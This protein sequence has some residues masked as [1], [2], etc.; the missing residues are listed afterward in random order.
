[1]GRLASFSLAI[2]VI[3]GFIGSSAAEEVCITCHQELGGELARAVKEWR[4]SVHQEAGVF[5]SFCHGGNPASYDHAMDKKTGFVSKPKPK[6]GVLLCARCHADVRMM[7]QY[8]LRTDQFSEYKTS[9]HGKLLWEKDDSNVAT[10]ISCHGVHNIMKKD[11]PYSSIFRLNIPE[12]CAKCHSDAKRMKAYKIP[13]DQFLQYR[14]SYHGRLLLEKG[15]PRAPTCA[16][17]HG[18]HGATPPGITEVANVCG[19]C[20]FVIASYFKEGPHE[21]SMREV[22]TP[23]CISCHGNHYIPTASVGL[24]S[25]EEKGHCG[26]CH[27][28]GTEPYKIAE[29][30]KEVIEGAE[31]R[32]KRAEEAI[33]NLKQKGLDVSDMEAAAVEARAKITQAKPVSHAL[34]LTK[35]KT[36]TDEA[37]RDVKGIELQAQ[38]LRRELYVRKRAL[39]IALLLTLIMI[40]LLY[41]KKR[42]LG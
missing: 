35:V 8:G 11:V 37:I 12:T 42:S 30:M 38:K 34:A 16:D 20:H 32:L 1:M 15:D 28:K 29:I 3:L 36:H 19:T 23:K 10:C 4:G 25:G 9:I 7:R 17:C 33:L 41:V 13:I 21:R 39:T 26:S 18:I 6:E 31:S 40:G 5:C 14:E 2:L 27:S 22:G 24:F